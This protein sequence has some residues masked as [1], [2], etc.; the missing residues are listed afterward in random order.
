[1]L[2]WLMGRVM[3]FHPA[4]CPRRGAGADRKW[5]AADQMTG[6]ACHKRSYPEWAR[7]TVTDSSG[8]PGMGRSRLVLEGCL[9]REPRRRVAPII[10]VT[11]HLIDLSVYY[12]TA[13]SLRGNNR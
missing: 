3:Y 5:R 13:R 4:Q 9:L 7:M 12:L 6:E 8:R 10:V 2:L 1:M 11:R